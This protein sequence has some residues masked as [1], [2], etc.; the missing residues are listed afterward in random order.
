MAITEGFR[1]QFSD[2]I[3]RVLQQEGSV[4]RKLVR[5]ETM[6]HEVEYFDTIQSSEA[7]EREHIA[8]QDDYNIT[9]QIGSSAVAG[10]AFAFRQPDMVRRQLSARQIFWHTMFDS[11]NDLNTLLKP[12]S[13]QVKDAVWA[14]G[15]QYDRTIIKAL[16]AKVRMGRTGEREV[17]YD[18]LNNV[19]PVSVALMVGTNIPSN[20]AGAAA[21]TGEHL[22]KAAK[23]GGL[24][25][26]KLMKAR[27]LL[28]RNAYSS[29]D[30]LY[31]VCTSDQISSLLH[32]SKLTSID[33][34]SVR[35]LVSGEVDTYL[36]FKFIISD[37]LP[38]IIP[39]D[40][41]NGYSIRDCYAFSENSMVFARVKGAF[42][43]N[44]DRLPANMDNILVKA[45]DSIGAVR[46]ED[47]SV[48]TVK[49]LEKYRPSHGV[50]DNRPKSANVD[51]R[52]AKHV[53]VIPASLY[54]N[55]EARVGATDING[56]LAVLLGGDKDGKVYDTNR[57]SEAALVQNVAVSV[58]V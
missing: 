48:V 6:N 56:A 20:S 47:T 16:T 22:I 34:N 1:Q 58:G 49:V 17:A 10:N 29:R 19:V 12:S 41:A 30:K 32:D 53:G 52:R 46:M 7:F 8:N 5:N 13:F 26:A 38:L 21:L 44:A 55:G 57:L 27:E 54:P 39:S 36:G 2:N 40:F 51:G 23:T 18:V 28:R 25:V 37:L 14:L 24:T 31:F 11:G 33:Y 50:A 9:D 45:I 43:G 4:L 35:A 42:K 3:N 15:R